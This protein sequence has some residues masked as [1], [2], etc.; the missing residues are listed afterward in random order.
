SNGLS[1]RCFPTAERFLESV[2][3]D[4]VGCLLLDLRM[5]GMAGHQLLQRLSGGT[6]MRPTI[7]ISGYADIPGVVKAMQ[8]GAIDV[9]E[10]PCPPRKLVES[11][12]SALETD[13]RDR[14]E[15]RCRHLDLSRIQSLSSIDRL[16]LGGIVRGLTNMQ[17]ANELEVSLRTV[18][19][20]RK[21]IFALLSVKSKA[22]LFRMIRS[23]GWWP[24]GPEAASNG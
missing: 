7:V 8:L 15:S 10:K 11:V 1:A 3:D 12:R 23:S 22:E 6:S 19:L 21:R 18:Q 14:G 13:I 16:I 17:I 20:R 4:D 9:L 5:P 2:N 24:A